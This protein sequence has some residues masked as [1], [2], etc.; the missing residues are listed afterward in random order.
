MRKLSEITESIWSDIQ[1]RSSGDT[2][3]KEDDINLLD[4]DGF[5]DY[6]VNH[7]EE[8]YPEHY[9]I[10]NLEKSDMFIIPM[11]KLLKEP[12]GK[13]L[14]LIIWNIDC[15]DDAF[16]TIPDESPFKSSNLFIKLRD[17]YKL[18]VYPPNFEIEPKS[19][20]DDINKSFFISVIDTILEL[21]TEYEPLIKKK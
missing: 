9:R 15:P 16:I 18:I 13:T 8:L 5:Y 3:R 21:N 7:Y 1:D 10:L 12:Y 17:K 6:L 4:R 14:N 2:V 20:K 19:E 11:L